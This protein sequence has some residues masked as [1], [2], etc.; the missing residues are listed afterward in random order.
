MSDARDNATTK[1]FTAKHARTTAL[2]SSDL[3]LKLAK[4]LRKVESSIECA[5]EHGLLCVTLDARKLYQAYGQDAVSTM[6]DIIESRGFKVSLFYP[7]L[8]IRW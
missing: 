1:P 5:A 8:E 6:Q 2:N 7:E 4:C 3:D